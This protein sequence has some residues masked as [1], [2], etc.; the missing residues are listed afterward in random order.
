[1]KKDIILA[2]LAIATLFLTNCS[3]DDEDSGIKVISSYETWY[4]TNIKQTDIANDQ[5]TLRLI[6]NGYNISS[7]P[8]PIYNE[9][10][11]TFDDYSIIVYTYIYSTTVEKIEYTPGK[12]LSIFAKH[13]YLV[14]P[15]KPNPICNFLKIKPKVPNNTPITLYIEGE[16]YY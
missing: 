2:A 12:G 10:N 13:K 14:N 6:L 16:K 3:K 11:G 4:R 8:E 15:A 5:S 9:L 7:M 1:M